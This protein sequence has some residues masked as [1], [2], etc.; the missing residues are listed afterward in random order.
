MAVTN[1]PPMTFRLISVIIG[2]I[3]LYV[4]LKAAKIPLFVPRNEWG[5]VLR[6]GVLNM[7][8]W[9]V[10]LM[11]VLPH[12]NSGRASVI[13]FTM[14][15]FSAIWGT[16]LYKQTVSVPQAILLAMAFAGIALLLT[17]EFLSLA[18][19]PLMVLFLLAATSIWALGAQQ[20]R[21]T[22]TKL[23]V[24]TVAFWM[25]VITGFGIFPFALVLEADKWV[26][27]S[28]NVVLAILFNAVA[29]FGFCHTGWAVLARNLNPFVSSVSISLIP[30]IGVLSG[31]YFLGEEMHWQD[32]VAI[33]CIG[34][35][36]LGVV[37]FG[38]NKRQLGRQEKLT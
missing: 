35:A 4:F 34:S 24:V 9:H 18:G 29:I 32:G 33:I 2:V 7:V 16:A 25:T 27:P 11:L 26:L 17:H 19:A 1:Y 12:L 31:A 6:L 14:P 22:P 3:V 28:T 15:V 36:V 8:V 10:A 23:N 30:V 20:L 37:L 5:R 38:N 13:A 21:R